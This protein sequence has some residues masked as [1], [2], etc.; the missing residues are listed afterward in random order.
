[1]I[2]RI[3]LSCHISNARQT[4]VQ[5]QQQVPKQNPLSE[6]GKREHVPTHNLELGL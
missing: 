4:E 5:D 6:R 2:V 3:L 1:M